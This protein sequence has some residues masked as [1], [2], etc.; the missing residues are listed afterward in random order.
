MDQLENGR[1]SLSAELLLYHDWPMLWSTSSHP[2]LVKNNLRCLNS[3]TWGRISSQ[4]GHSFPGQQ[5]L[6]QI[7]LNVFFCVCFFYCRLHNLF[8]NK[9]RLIGKIRR[10]RDWPVFK[11][12]V[13]TKAKTVSPYSGNSP[14]C[15]QYLS[16]INAFPHRSVLELCATCACIHL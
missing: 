15:Q 9:E 7:W 1:L 4:F 13:V 2:S 11:V 8:T 5:P 10:A 12:E 3:S 16:V 14:L 6:N